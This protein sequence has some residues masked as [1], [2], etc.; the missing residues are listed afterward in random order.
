MSNLCVSFITYH[1]HKHL[2]LLAILMPIKT[3]CAV[4]SKVHGCL[5]FEVF[6][7]FP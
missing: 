1:R 5:S 7:Q 6:A 2:D 3:E 4:S